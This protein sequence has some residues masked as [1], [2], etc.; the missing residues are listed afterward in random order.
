MS[1]SLF[2][3]LILFAGFG[4][5]PAYGRHSVYTKDDVARIDGNYRAG[6]SG[7]SEDDVP[8]VLVRA[9]TQPSPEGRGLIQEER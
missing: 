3:I 6:S 7:T 2:A 9:L 4:V 5:R 1:K 8:V